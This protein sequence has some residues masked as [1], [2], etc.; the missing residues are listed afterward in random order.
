MTISFHH[1]FRS[2]DM[3]LNQ[4]MDVVAE[5]GIKDLTIVPSSLLDVHAPLVDHIK[6]MVL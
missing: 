3:V 4:V 1:H 2:G 5:M 6:K